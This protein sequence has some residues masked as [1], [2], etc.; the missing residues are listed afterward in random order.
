MLRNLSCLF[1]LDM[2]QCEISSSVKAHNLIICGNGWIREL[3]DLIWVYM[4]LNLFN[5]VKLKNFKKWMLGIKISQ[6]K[7][8]LL[9]IDMNKQKMHIGIISLY[10]ILRVCISV[11]HKK[12]PQKN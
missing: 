2:C 7:L 11:S 1:L 12:Q 9:W 8:W 4:F 10:I 3:F 6:I 5:D